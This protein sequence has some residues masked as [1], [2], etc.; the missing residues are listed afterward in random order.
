MP[1]I[2]VTPDGKMTFVRSSARKKKPVH[3]N[4][5]IKAIFHDLSSSQEDLEQSW[6]EPDPEYIDLYN[7][8][9]V[10]LWKPN[11][12]PQASKARASDPKAMGASGTAEKDPEHLP[13]PESGIL[14]AGILGAAILG[15][16]APMLGVKP[17]AISLTGTLPVRPI[18]TDPEL[19]AYLRDEVSNSG[20][21]VP[22]KHMH[23][24]ASRSA[25]IL[26]FPEIIKKDQQSF[27]VM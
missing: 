11:S 1:H 21:S 17:L 24:H 20:H 6:P 12:I 16:N 13:N 5:K 4:E 2:E 26:Q 14:E 9:V 22:L 8:L 7:T 25:N 3:N 27:G 23:M 18:Q 19:I 10:D 15:V